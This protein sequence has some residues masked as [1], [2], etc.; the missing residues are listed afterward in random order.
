MTKL[1]AYLYLS[2]VSD[3]VSFLANIIL[4]R[5]KN[6]AKRLKRLVKLVDDGRDVRLA[7]FS[8]DVL[9]LDGKKVEWSILG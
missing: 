6:P 4:T 1:Q 5:H 2:R 9:L 8:C 3:E 7:G